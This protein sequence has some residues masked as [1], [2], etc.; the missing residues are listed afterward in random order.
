MPSN[1]NRTLDLLI[2]SLLHTKS[3]IQ[4]NVWAY[5]V[6]LKMKMA[7]DS[8]WKSLGSYVEVSGKLP[9][10]CCHSMYMSTLAV[11]RI[12]I[13]IY[14]LARRNLLWDILRLPSSRR[15]ALGLYVFL[16][17]WRA[18]GAN[19]PPYAL[20]HIG[21]HHAMHCAPGGTENAELQ[22]LASAAKKT[23]WI[24]PRGDE[25]SNMKGVNCTVA[26]TRG[27]GILIIDMYNT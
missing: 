16:T 21:A 6:G 15:A 8:R 26:W 19:Q 2:R 11:I 27:P 9:L 3:M 22:W 7:L 10:P 25:S 13:R 17:L 24:L 5:E 1:K 18:R 4:Y 14:L 23:H 12:R 20:L